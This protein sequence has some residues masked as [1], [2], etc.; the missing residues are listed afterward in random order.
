MMRYT[1]SEKMPET[2]KIVWAHGGV[3]EF[4]VIALMV[5]GDVA[6]WAVDEDRDFVLHFYE[7]SI[8]RF[9]DT[10]EE[11][12]PRYHIDAVDVT[13]DENDE[14]IGHPDFHEIMADIEAEPAAG[15][16]FIP[17]AKEVYTRSHHI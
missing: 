6:V 7:P 15:T 10:Y 3:G 14:V 5:N 16:I 4:D 17:G 12:I 1:G 13:R 2:C 8:G 9:I 11:Y